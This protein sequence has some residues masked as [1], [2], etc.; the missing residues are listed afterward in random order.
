MEVVSD[1]PQSHVRDY[2][3]KLV[4]YARA[5]IP[6]YWI[7]DPQAVTISVMTLAA[8]K[9]E[10]RGVYKA[11]EEASSQLLNGLCVNVSD[12]FAAGKR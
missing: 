5:G 11:G 1:D 2:E 9:Y 6:E 8:G 4:D 12:V 10:T 7:V 3:Q